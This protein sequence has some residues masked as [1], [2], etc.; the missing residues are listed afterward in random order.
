MINSYSYAESFQRNYYELFNAFHPS[1][2]VFLYNKVKLQATTYIKF[3]STHAAI[4]SRRY[5]LEK[6]TLAVLTACS[7]LN[8][9][10]GKDGSHIYSNWC[11]CMFYFWRK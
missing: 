9:G 6:E 2:F 8:K 4:V 3:G 1:M 11:N 7:K 5:V 10:G